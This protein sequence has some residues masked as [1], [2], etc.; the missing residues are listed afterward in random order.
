[1]AV[2]SVVAVSA[3]DQGFSGPW[4]LP[5]FIVCAACVLGYKFF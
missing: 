5:V 3:G 4:V 2:S 1:V